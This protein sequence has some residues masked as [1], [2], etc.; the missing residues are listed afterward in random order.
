MPDDIRQIAA[1]RDRADIV[2]VVGESVKLIRRGRSLVG[3]CPFHK[4]K[5]PSFQAVNPDHNFY[6]C[7]GCHEKGDAIG[8]V[9]KT[10]GLDFVEAVRTG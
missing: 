7:F 8:F 4:E 6:Y 3:L 9:M 2:R 1:V 10:E 5:S